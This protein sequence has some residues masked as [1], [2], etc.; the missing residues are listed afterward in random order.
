MRNVTNRRETKSKV[1]GGFSDSGQ[2]ATLAL[3][4]PRLLCN[5]DASPVVPVCPTAAPLSIGLGVVEQVQQFP[6]LI[7]QSVPSRCHRGALAR[8]P[9][10]EEPSPMP[11]LE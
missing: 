11:Q 6:Q 5:G 9:P 7:W 1:R 8:G 2:V 4:E 3:T 10:C